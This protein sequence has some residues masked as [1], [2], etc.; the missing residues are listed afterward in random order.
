MDE[1]LCYFFLE[2]NQ[3][4]SDPHDEVRSLLCVLD[5]DELA[6]T[7]MHAMQMFKRSPLHCAAQFGDFV[8][9]RWLVEHGALLNTK[10]AVRLDFSSLSFYLSI[11]VSSVE[12]H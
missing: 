11:F 4:L 12:R 6:H 10:D 2:K 5:R 1:W 8:S 7:C 9:L 3:S